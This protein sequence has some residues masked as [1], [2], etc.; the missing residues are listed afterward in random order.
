MNQTINGTVF[1]VRTVKVPSNRVQG[2][3][4]AYY[5]DGK[6]VSM[7]EWFAIKREEKDKAFAAEYGA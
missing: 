7:A 5:V 4:A 2:Q 1:E 6:R 3:R